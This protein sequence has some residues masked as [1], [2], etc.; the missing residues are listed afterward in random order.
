MHPP[1]AIR[2]AHNADAPAVLVEA[3]LLGGEEEGVPV[4]SAIAEGEAAQ[5]ARNAAGQSEL[6]VGGGIDRSGAVAVHEH[7]LGDRPP[8]VFLSQAHAGEARQ[9]GGDAA[10]LV[11]GRRLRSAAAKDSP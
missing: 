8:V 6:F 2:L 5:L 1:P 11:L 9:A 7:R 4:V 10:R 3:F